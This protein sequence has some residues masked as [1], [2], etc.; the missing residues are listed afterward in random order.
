MTNKASIHFAKCRP[1]AAPERHNMRQYSNEDFRPSYFLP[2][3]DQEPNTV[4]DLLDP[5]NTDAAKAA[6][7]AKAYF[8]QVKE[9]YSGRGKRAKY[10]NCRREAILNLSENSTEE[11]LRGVVRYLDE[12]WHIKTTSYAIHRDEGYKDQDG[13]VHR[14]LHAHLVL[15]TLYVD[16][17]T[18]K[19]K[20]AWSAIGRAELHQIQD[21][22]A[23]IM[24]MERTQ[25]PGKPRKHLTRD[26]YVQVKEAQ[27][28]AAQ[29]TKQAAL[30]I[31]QART[32]KAQATEAA[33]AAALETQQAAKA[34]AEAAKQ[35]AQVRHDIETHKLAPSGILVNRALREANAA[36]AEQ[37]DKLHQQ[38][39]WTDAK[40]KSDLADKDRQIQ[41]ARDETDAKRQTIKQLREQIQEQQQTI[42][43]QQD[44]ITA[45]RAAAKMFAR[46]Q[47]YYQC[48]IVPDEERQQDQANLFEIIKD[49]VTTMTDTVMSIFKRITTAINEEINPEVRAARLEKEKAAQARAEAAERQ[50]QAEEARKKT[51]YRGR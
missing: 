14:N 31:E 17:E 29:A 5:E 43:T 23:K 36:Q 50:R 21:D 46:M 30:E 6:D 26:S 47:N 48:K 10:D 27:D 22:I 37:I 38:A 1:G 41:E 32:A 49:T 9:H 51:I 11:D 35:A 28:R 20:Q 39:A 42:K 18:G 34:K 15:E 40:H 3:A 24:K 16:P 7:N 12:R 2:E 25:T 19:P 33:H 4:R 45:T 13:A 8:D 44:E